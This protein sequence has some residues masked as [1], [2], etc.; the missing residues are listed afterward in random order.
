ME[1][2]RLRIK[3]RLKEYIELDISG[4]R[5]LILKILLKFRKV[6]VEIMWKEINKRF[7]ISYNA[8]ASTLGYIDSKI[9]ILH[10]HK[11]SYKTPTVYSLKEEYIDIIQKVLN[12]GSV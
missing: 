10:S 6:T 2:I 3:R 4:I 8:V 7:K 11:E 12:K 1:S 9:G 5:K